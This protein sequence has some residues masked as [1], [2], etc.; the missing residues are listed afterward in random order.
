M[1]ADDTYIW[2][3]GMPYISGTLCAHAAK[4]CSRLLDLHSRT[5]AIQWSKTSLD[6]KRQKC[7]AGR[8]ISKGPFSGT[9]QWNLLVAN[10]LKDLVHNW[11]S[12]TNFV[13]KVAENMGRTPLTELR[14]V[15]LVGQPEDEEL[16]V[17]EEEESAVRLVC[18]YSSQTHCSWGRSF[19]WTIYLPGS[20]KVMCL[21]RSL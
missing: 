17:G 7:T 15:Q 4:L 13:R 1:S 19:R 18:L 8:I 12:N 2:V 5:I 21:N 10:F 14:K 11:F 16:Q 3:Q 20:H 6:K 9:I